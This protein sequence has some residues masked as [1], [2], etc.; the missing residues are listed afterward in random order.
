MH[1]QLVT[2]VP[3]VSFVCVPQVVYQIMDIVLLILGINARFKR[4]DLTEQGV[5]RKLAFGTEE[6]ENQWVF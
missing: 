5:C 3:V 6:F 1:E 4:L 2:L